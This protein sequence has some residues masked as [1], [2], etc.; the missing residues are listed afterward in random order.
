M[1]CVNGPKKLGIERR[2]ARTPFPHL[3]FLSIFSVSY[4]NPP[5]CCLF[6]LRLLQSLLPQKPKQTIS[7][8][9][10]KM[11]FAPT[12]C[13]PP[14][15][16]ERRYPANIV[17]EYSLRMWAISRWRGGRELAELFLRAGF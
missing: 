5:S 10:T 14:T 9:K 7:N 12:F 11:Q 15:M 13:V 3:L 16:P 17:V 4:L 8:E 2:I 1:Q 6:H